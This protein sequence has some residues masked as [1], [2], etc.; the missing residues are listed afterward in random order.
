MQEKNNPAAFRKQPFS[1][2]L[3]R[4]RLRRL[5]LPSSSPSVQHGEK[6][7]TPARA[8]SREGGR[9]VRRTRAW[10]RYQRFRRRSR[11]KT[12]SSWALGASAPSDIGR[13]T[14][15]CD[16]RA[17]TARTC[18][19]PCRVGRARVCV[20]DAI[21]RSAARKL[22]L[23][24]FPGTGAGAGEREA[25]P[26]T[27]SPLTLTCPSPHPLRWPGCADLPGKAVHARADGRGAM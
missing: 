17:W 26:A 19:A 18:G 22:A 15:T 8:V 23:R 25:K 10:H 27:P 3:S 13:P 21:K 1:A 20:R 12:A 24:P 5:P 2:P 11:E 16:R 7:P 9:Q 6:P 14:R 4:R